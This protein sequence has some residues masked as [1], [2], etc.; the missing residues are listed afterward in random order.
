MQL[1]LFDTHNSEQPWTHLVTIDEFTNWR[2]A[3]LQQEGLDFPGCD[4]ESRMIYHDAEE[5]EYGRKG[6]W[7]LYK[8]PKE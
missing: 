7:Q 1:D 2:R 6:Y 4:H 8:H 5:T 3:Q